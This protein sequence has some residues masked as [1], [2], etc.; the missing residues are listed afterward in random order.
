MLGLSVEGES[1]LGGRR[2]EMTH[3]EIPWRKISGQPNLLAHAYGQID[4]ELLYRTAVVDFPE[5][6]RQMQVLLPAPECDAS[7]ARRQL[8]CAPQRVE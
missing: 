6:V 7:C 2:V 3:P 5:S 4:H 1:D 8:P